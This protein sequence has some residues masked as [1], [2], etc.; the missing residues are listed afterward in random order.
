MVNK[1]RFVIT[2]FLLVISFFSNTSW[3]TDKDFLNSLSVNAKI[4]SHP[5][6]GETRFIAIKD[7]V[8]VVIKPGRS[9][10]ETIADTYA[11]AFGLSSP[12]I[13]LK[14]HKQTQHSDSG[15][16]LRFQ[17]H[18]KGVPVMGAE[19]V[20]GVDA[21]NQVKYVAGETAPELL[22]DV[23]SQISAEKATAVARVA[24]AK[25]YSVNSETLA[26]SIAELS[27]FN[28]A[29]ISPSK[30]PA[31]LVWKLTVTSNLINELVLV[32]ANN[33]SIAFNL[34]Q[35][36]FAL[37]RATY[38]ANN[39]E[40]IPGTF[41]CGEADPT[42]TAGDADARAAHLYVADAYNFYSSTHGRDGIT[43]LGSTIVTSVHY[44]PIG[45]GNAAWTG[46]GEQMYFGDGYAQAD[47]VV[48]HEFTHGVTQYES[49]LFSY[50]QA[51]SIAES[52]SDVWGEFVDQTNGAGSDTAAD[53]WLMGEDLPGGAI[54]NMS[55][56]PAFLDPDRMTSPNY[57]T[58]NGASNNVHTN[59]GVNNKAVYLM[60][61]GSGSEAGGV[62]NGE[63]VSALGITKVATL[64]YEV[65]TKFLTSGSDYLDLYN[66]LNQ[67]CS[68]LVTAGTAGFVSSDC[69]QVQ[70]ALTAV[71]MN[72]QPVN[73]FNPEASLCPSGGSVG[74]VI[75]SDDIESGISN[76]T[77]TRDTSLANSDW[78]QATGYARSGT[79]ALF[80]ENVSTRSDQYAQISVT[81]P[82]TSDKLFLHFN[83]SIEL[84]AA[85][86]NYYDGA[87]VEYSTNNGTSWNDAGNLI[88]DGKI[89]TGIIN[90]DF[91][92]PLAGRLAF[93]GS[94]NGY[95]STRFN[96]SAFANSTLLLRWRLATDIST[97]NL[98]WVIDDVS[99]YSCLAPLVGSL[100]VAK[101]GADQIVNPNAVVTLNGSASSDV[102]D[103]TISSF[104]WEQVGGQNVSLSNPA[105]ATPA[106]TASTSI[107]IV[108]FRLTV[109]DLDN[110][111][112]SDIVNII[113]TNAPVANAGD[114]FAV[115]EGAT[116]TLDGSASFDTGGSIVSY[117]WTQTTGDT[118]T[119]SNENTVSPTFTAPAAGQV[120][121]FSLTVTDNNGNS[122]LL[123]DTVNVTVNSA[124]SIE[125]SGGGGC[126]LNPQAAFNP[127]MF[128]LL[129]GLSVIHLWRGRRKRT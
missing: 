56:P 95:V 47:D 58:G 82:V 50:Y 92:N 93:S 1:Q 10:S 27:I 5:V 44:G 41:I 11:P 54:R 77:L 28:P 71:E 3:A 26:V 36:H 64:Y 88:V 66:A 90:A 57:F 96:L 119:L 46:T 100:P 126:S 102:D 12:A 78:R 30:M 107:E 108:S 22:L 35:I 8:P 16:T 76:W 61:D 128:I 117:A 19:L 32:D 43:G 118:V 127:F 113:V 104:L 84:E 120:L 94:S 103:G 91:Q 60:V 31:R 122:S 125:N 25:W 51:G 14:F 73:D 52:F 42:C 89:Y 33:A 7:K 2:G 70:A 40:T 75:F 111:T 55:N 65:Q 63:T 110:N 80:S 121:V 59:G 85:A 67:A 53:K 69:T 105:S 15:K 49:N 21:S 48:A 99:V 45:F 34:N 74:S 109:T 124:P 98:G 4:H 114:D 18:Y 9:L 79:I 29:L 72:L 62:F 38:T 115:A 123:L 13:E 112:D 23:T 6:T 86:G 116:A 106:F 68:D 17:Q 87:V 37:S 24:V 39:T 83:H 101:A 97:A 81:L 20:V 129:L